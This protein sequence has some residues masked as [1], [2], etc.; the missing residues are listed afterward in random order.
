MQHREAHHGRTPAQGT[1]LGT[2]RSGRARGSGDPSHLPCAPAPRPQADPRDEGGRAGPQACPLAWW[3][4]CSHLPAS[5]L[6]P[7]PGLRGDGSPLAP[8]WPQGEGHARRLGV[9][10]LA[11]PL[12]PFY[13]PR[14]LASEGPRD[15]RRE[16]EA[17]ARA[18]REWPHPPPVAAG[19][20]RPQVPRPSRSPLGC[21][22]RAPQAEGLTPH[23]PRETDAQGKGR[24]RWKGSARVARHPQDCPLLPDS[25]VHPSVLCTWPY[26]QPRPLRPSFLPIHTCPLRPASHSLNKCTQD[27]CGVCARPVGAAGPCHGSPHL[28]LALPLPAPAARTPAGLGSLCQRLSLRTIPARSWCR[29]AGQAPAPCGCWVLDLQ[30]SY[31]T[32]QF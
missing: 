20:P 17:G 7:E 23:G 3:A 5:R 16:A 30:L 26:H 9:T 28:H 15:Y 25:L 19:C 14:D 2:W 1:S 13:R 11:G 12:C 4:S 29:P 21:R 24:I 31:W 10:L 6:P 8:H 32:A 18:H 22:D 27:A